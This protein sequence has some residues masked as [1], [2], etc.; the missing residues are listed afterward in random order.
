MSGIPGYAG[1]APVQNIGAYGAEAKDV[2]ESV[3]VMYADGLR[4]GLLT[5]R[6]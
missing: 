3:E 2:I 5:N 4:E 6:M 1:A